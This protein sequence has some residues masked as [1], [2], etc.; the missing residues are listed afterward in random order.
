MNRAGRLPCCL[1]GS[2]AQLAPGWVSPS[3]ATGPVMAGS[4]LSGRIVLTP[5]PGILKAMVSAPAAALAAL[6][7]SRSEQ[8]AVLHVPSSASLLELTV[9]SVPGA[10]PQR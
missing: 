6:M 5:P 9:K 4:G 1:A 10:A 7:A 3:I 8:W 2:A